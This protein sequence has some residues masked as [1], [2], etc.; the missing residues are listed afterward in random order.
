MIIF[1][2]DGTIKVKPNTE[3]IVCYPIIDSND[4][5]IKR[6]NPCNVHNII[7]FNN[8]LRTCHQYKIPF[9]IYTNNEDLLIKNKI[10]HYR[11]FV[12]TWHNINS[13]FKKELNSTN[14]GEFLLML[15]I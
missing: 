1:N 6:S 12:A 5:T 10:I 11:Y 13:F 4:G 3:Y 8:I 7:E 14:Y 9:V 2:D 15:N